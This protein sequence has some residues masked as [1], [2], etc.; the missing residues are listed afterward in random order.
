MDIEH[1]LAE[2]DEPIGTRQVRECT[3]SSEA[4]LNDI[5]TLS[6]PEIRVIGV[7]G[8]GNNFITALYDKLRSHRTVETIAINTDAGQLS[9]SKAHKRIL[10]GKDTTKGHGAGNDPRL[11]RRAFEE[12]KEKIRNLIDGSDLLVVC[13]GLGGGTGSGVAP[14]IVELAS[15]LNILTISFVTIPFKC[16]GDVRIRNALDSLDSIVRNSTVTIVVPNERL[17]KLAPRKTIHG[18]FDL[19]N[20]ILIQLIRSLSDLIEKPGLINVDFADVKKILSYKGLA[21]PGVSEVSDADDKR[22]IVAAERI[23]NNPL[24]EVNPAFGKGA[25]IEIVAGEDLLLSEAY[26]IVSR[27]TTVLGED[28]E[29]IFG[30]RIDPSYNSKLRI[31][32][33]ITGIDIIGDGYGE[34]TNVTDGFANDDALFEDLKNVP[35]LK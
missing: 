27:F 18:A 24:L 30:L 26:D 4:T 22:A 3:V 25:L 7:G 32:S 15:E 20:N 6:L 10:I 14:G 9:V 33:L 17:I 23:L 16:E 21:L 8:A 1:L 31:A 19:A 29:I 13:A 5:I 12:S 2:F 11:G 35:I 34:L 28:K